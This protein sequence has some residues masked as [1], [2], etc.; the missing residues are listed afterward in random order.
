MD[1]I[2]CALAPGQTEC[3]IEMVM[4]PVF[5]LLLLYAERIAGGYSVVA[6]A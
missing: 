2:F 1:V 6:V 3:L 5:Q 4:E